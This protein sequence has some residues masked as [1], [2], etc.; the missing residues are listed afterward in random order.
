[1][2]PIT[3]IHWLSLKCHV[4]F[5]VVTRLT[6][7]CQSGDIPAISASDS[8]F[9]PQNTKCIPAVK[10]FIFFDLAENTSFLDGHYLGIVLRA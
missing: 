10:I 4:V 6:D 5:V 9:N 3:P 1:G 7:Q 2:N 8:D